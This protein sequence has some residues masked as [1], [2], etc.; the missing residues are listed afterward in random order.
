MGAYHCA[1]RIIRVGAR[2]AVPV[3]RN[4]LLPPVPDV[5][6]GLAGNREETLEDVAGQEAINVV[7]RVIRHEIDDEV[8]GNRRD[9]P[10]KWLIPETLVVVSLRE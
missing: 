5:G 10:C 1:F 2:A 4:L 3:L 7:G 8:V 9:E 6:A